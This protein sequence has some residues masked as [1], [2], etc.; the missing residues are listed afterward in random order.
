[1][2]LSHADLTIRFYDIS[3]QLLLSMDPLKFEYPQVLPHL[4]LE[5]ARF[6]PLLPATEV[7]GIKSVHLASISSE[8]VAVLSTGDVILWRLKEAGKPGQT[9][10]IPAEDAHLFVPLES[11]IRASERRL[12]SFHPVCLIRP[13]DVGPDASMEVTASALSDVGE[14]PQPSHPTCD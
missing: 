6:L 8:C 7:I 9:Y 2:I 13:P 5:V 14:V 3:S 12:S 10:N 11:F 4:T 1:M